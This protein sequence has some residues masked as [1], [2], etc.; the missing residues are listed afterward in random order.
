ME[1]GKNP[2]LNPACARAEEPLGA[3]FGLGR[4]P[5]ASGLFSGPRKARSGQ[6]NT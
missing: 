1:M 4:A 2:W 5:W 6:T 3:S